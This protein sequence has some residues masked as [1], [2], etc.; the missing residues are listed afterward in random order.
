M[1]FFS[2]ALL[3]LSALVAASLAVPVSPPSVAY[4]R[5][6]HPR[7]PQVQH[8]DLIKREELPKRTPNPPPD[9]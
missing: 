8:G 5:L 2:S 9:W 3:A 6:T 7:P 1:R 4:A